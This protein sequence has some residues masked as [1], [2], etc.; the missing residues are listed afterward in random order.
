[1][2]VGLRTIIFLG[3]ALLLLAP[4]IVAGSMFTDAMQRRAEVANGTRLR[5]LGE[6]AADQLGRHMH[7][8]WQDVEGMASIVSMDN[9]EETRQRFNLLGQVGP[10]PMR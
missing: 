2:R 6:I 10:A 8:L 1:M 4:A 7:Q 9:P 5:V 3:G